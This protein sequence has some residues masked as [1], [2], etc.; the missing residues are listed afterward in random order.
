[1]PRVVHFEIMADD[2]D[3]AVKFFKKVFGWRINKWEGPVD[4]WLIKND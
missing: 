4:Y 3:R 1:M 2:P